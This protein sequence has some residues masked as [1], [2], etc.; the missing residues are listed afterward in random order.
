LE[1]FRTNNA[2]K[3][4]GKIYHFVFANVFI[5]YGIFIIILFLL[6]RIIWRIIF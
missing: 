3:S 4:E 5:F 6:L 2:E 1:E